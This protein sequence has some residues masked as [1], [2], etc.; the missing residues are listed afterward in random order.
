[1]K[2]DE[3]TEPYMVGHWQLDIV[4]LDPRENEEHSQIALILYLW[5]F[6]V[7]NSAK[8]SRPPPKSHRKLQLNI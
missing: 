4:N 1:M 7:F 8:H 2:F 5:L 3:Y 6:S